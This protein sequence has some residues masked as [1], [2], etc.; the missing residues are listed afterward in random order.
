MKRLSFIASGQKFE[1]FPMKFIG[2]WFFGMLFICL[3]GMNSCNDTALIGSE[4]LENEQADVEFLDTISF[5]FTTQKGDSIL[6][7]APSVTAS[8]TKLFGEYADPVFGKATA[9]IYFRI[10]GL[11][12]DPEFS[13]STLDSVVLILPYDTANFYGNTTA[14]FGM[15]ILPIQQGQKLDANAKYY[16]SSTLP[17]DNSPVAEKVFKTNGRDSLTIKEPDGGKAKDTKIKSHLRVKMN[18]AF[19]DG[20]FAT[21]AATLKNDSAFVLKYPGFFI[22]PTMAGKGMLAFNFTDA[23]AGLSVYY[24]KDTVF[25]K[26]EF[27]FSRISFVNLEHDFKGSTV[28]SFFGNEALGDSLAFAQGMEGVKFKVAFP[29][30]PALK[31]ILVNKAELEFYIAELP[32]DDIATYE[33]ATQLAALKMTTDT[34]TT[35]LSDFV[36]AQTFRGNIGGVFGGIPVTDSKTGLKKYKMNLSTHFQDYLRGEE[37]KDFSITVYQRSIKAGRAVVYGPKHSKYPAKFKLYY[38]IPTN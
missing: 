10:L 28:E 27:P 23:L 13:Q 36:F 38:T 7:Y 31:D 26:V 30:L 4:L 37:K 25:R 22:R 29:A 32:G 6:M 15:D 18:S 12:Q 19:A 24:H 21:E 1:H 34:T 33:P 14:E 2:G 16:S 5:H 35:E 3:M 8:S 11:T 17:T 20:L 9:G